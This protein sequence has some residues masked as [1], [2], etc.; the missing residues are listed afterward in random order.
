MIGDGERIA[1]SAVAELE[2]TLKVG[3]PKVVGSGALRQGCAGGA[4]AL[5]AHAFD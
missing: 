5:L 3:T 1:V 2:L 4:M